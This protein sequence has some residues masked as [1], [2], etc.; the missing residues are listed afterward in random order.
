MVWVSPDVMSSNISSAS[1]SLWSI[2]DSPS[3]SRIGRGGSR[4][5]LGLAALLWCSLVAGLRLRL[6]F[7]H[8]VLGERPGCACLVLLVLLGVCFPVPLQ[9][10]G[11][12]VLFL[13]CV[14]WVHCVFGVWALGVGARRLLLV[15]SVSCSFPLLGVL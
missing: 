1:L 8:W 11:L 14:F 9:W 6:A 3:Q 7:V 2:D 4:L 10:V 5:A 13:V 15:V 12:R